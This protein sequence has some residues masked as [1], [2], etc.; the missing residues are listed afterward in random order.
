MHGGTRHGSSQSDTQRSS[1]LK[2]KTS[3]VTAHVR[4][5]SRRIRRLATASGIRDSV[6][7]TRSDVQGT[8]G[9]TKSRVART[10]RFTSTRVIVTAPHKCGRPR[11]VQSSVIAYGT[12]DDVLNNRSDVRDINGSAATCN[13]AYRKSDN[14]DSV[15]PARTFAAY[16]KVQNGSGHQEQWF[17]RISGSRDSAPSGCDSAEDIGTTAQDS[18]KCT[19]RTDSDSAMLARTPA[20]DCEDSNRGRPSNP[21]SRKSNLEDHGTTRNDITRRTHKNKS[22]LAQQPA[23]TTPNLATA[24]LIHMPTAHFRE[25]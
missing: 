18:L 19:R 14:S 20:T 10:K 22:H 21:G 13:K 7:S 11:R 17:T 24:R 3:A 23:C 15:N 6:C 5:R 1:E 8:C 25:L 9:S 2:R 12:C 4:G 16:A